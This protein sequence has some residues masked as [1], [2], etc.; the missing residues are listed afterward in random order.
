[1]EGV[2]MLGQKGLLSIL[3]I[4]V[5]TLFLIGCNDEAAQEIET[6]AQPAD[7]ALNSEVIDQDEHLE[8]LVR[9]GPQDRL[10]GSLKFASVS[11]QAAGVDFFNEQQNHQEDRNSQETSTVIDTSDQKPQ[12]AEQVAETDQVQPPEPPEKQKEEEEKEPEKEEADIE[13]EEEFQP[14]KPGTMEYILW[15]QG[16]HPSQKK[17]SP[18]TTT[19]TTTTIIQDQEG[20]IYYQEESTVITTN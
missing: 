12:Q 6:A 9:Y 3:C 10:P 19:E 2:K 15:Q 7:Q 8:D 4:L 11:L 18:Q 13:P 20:G 17:Q 14:P 16:K 1:M 5:F